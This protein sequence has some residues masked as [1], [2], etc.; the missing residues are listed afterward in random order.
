M[1]VV[2]AVDQGV[3][4]NFICFGVL[5]LDNGVHGDEFTWDLGGIDG[6]RGLDHF[7]QVLDVRGRG[8]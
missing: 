2:F 3:D 1:V 7:E 8:A 6:D 4:V 5:D